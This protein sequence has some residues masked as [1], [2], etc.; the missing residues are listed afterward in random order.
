M[1]RMRRGRREGNTGAAKEAEPERRR[2]SEGGGG[3]VIRTKG[4]NRTLPGP[5]WRD[6]RTA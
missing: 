5:S 4:H 6:F 1:K 3:A 2:S